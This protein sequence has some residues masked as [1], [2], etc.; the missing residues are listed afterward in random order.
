MSKINQNNGTFFCKGEK[1]VLR[2]DG[3]FIA[4][5]IEI[6]HEQTKD[7]FYRSIDFDQENKTYF[8]KVGYERL[9][10]EVE[11]TALF[12]RSIDRTKSGY[13]ANLTNKESVGIS[14]SSLEYQPN[15]AKHGLYLIVKDKPVPMN[16]AKFLSAA[17]YDLLK[18]LQQTGSNYFLLNN[19]NEFQIT[20]LQTTP[21][22]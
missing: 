22:K 15:P 8:L 1:I 12:V 13:I 18:D 19:G 2:R 21:S 17:Y 3:I 14:E 6:T 5:G 10:I 4:D 11:D 20:T 16:R 9:D 7:L